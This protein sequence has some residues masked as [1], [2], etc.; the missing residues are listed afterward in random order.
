MNKKKIQV[1]WGGKIHK[2]KKNTVIQEYRNG[3][4]KGRIQ[5]NSKVVGLEV[6][7][8]Q[9]QNGYT[10]QRKNEKPIGKRYGLSF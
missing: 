10:L 9:T 6:L 5:L 8:F 2:V 7:Y 3:G 1:L 4:L